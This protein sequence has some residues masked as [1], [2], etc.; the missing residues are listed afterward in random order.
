MPSH[1]LQGVAET[2]KLIESGRVLL[3]A[4][5]EDLLRQLPAGTWIG[6]TSANFMTAEGGQSRQDILF[7]SDI[8]DVAGKAEVR[9]YSA[10]SLR[11]LAA[12]YPD[13]GFTVLNVP[14]LSEI[15]A[16]FAKGAPD[17]EGVFNAPLFGWIS[18][19]AV[20][21]IGKRAPKVFA[22]NGEPLADMAA[23]MHVAAP[24]GKMINIDIINIFRQGD[25]PDIVFDQDG[26]ESAGDCRIG[27]ERANLAEFIQR[28][29]IDTKLPLVADYNGAMI[30]V[31]IREVDSAAGKVT[32]YA[33]VFHGVEYRVAR[34]VGEYLQEFF[35]Q[36]DKI[37][38]DKI[39]LSCNC[40]LNYLYANLEGKRTGDIV[41]PIT[42]GEI[43][44][45][46]LNQTLVYATVEDRPLAA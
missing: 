34:P 44:Y 26:F 5:D 15:H 13:N 7:V 36:L 3:L 20:S 9:A 23:A 43:A 10:D 14:G 33:P 38:L 40:I 22:G 27:G 29:N 32:F 31:S 19:V 11:D 17:Y 24:D 18:G 21:E 12:N 46:L 8:T 4:G 42:F 1:S 37:N 35:A 16:A 6:G 41:G 28:N 30:N 2:A 39:A 25:G 45:M